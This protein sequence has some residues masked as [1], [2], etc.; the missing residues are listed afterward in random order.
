[1]GLRDSEALRRMKEN[2]EWYVVYSRP[3]CEKKI[4]ET[5]AESGV[6]HYCPLNK[7]EKQWSDRR[8]TVLEPLFK[9]YVFVQ[10]EEKHKWEIRKVDGVLN[11]VHWLGKP[12]IVPQEEIDTIRKF[13]HEFDNVTVTNTA[14]HVNDAVVIKQGIMMDYH[15]LVLEITGNR[16]KVQIKSMGVELSA[17][18]EKSNLSPL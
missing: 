4:A 9:G 7:V 3:R 15:G 13:L 14:I 2:L 1:M 11:F 8:K 5:L 18:F 10:L 6:G 12:A 16:A 17:V